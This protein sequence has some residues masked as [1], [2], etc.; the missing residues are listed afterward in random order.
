ME[1]RYLVVPGLRS[2]RI[3]IV[4]TK[5]DPRNPKIVKVIE[6]E[7]LAKRTGYSRPHTIHCGPDGIYVS[8]LGSPEGEG[9]GGIFVMDP[10]TFEV[11]GKWELDRGPQ[12]FSYD[13]WWHLG[14]DTMITSE[15]G[16]PKMF[17]NG[18]IPEAILGGEYG[19]ALH[20]WDLHKRRHKQVL[21]LGP[22]YQLP[23]ELRPA[24]DPTQAYGFV[25]VV[26]SNEDLSAS[27]W[28]WYREGN[29]GNTNWKI[30]SSM[31]PAG[32]PGNCDSMT[33]PTPSTPS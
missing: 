9:P 3:H 15:W 29:N 7:T 14:H 23:F 30:T 32:A 21:E 5:P 19:H 10:E 1:R 2:S 12:Y 25:G 20:V 26:I 11:K 22:Q 4:D 28:L 31:C 16:T 33:S 18:L 27:V 8:A 17:E 13:F 24:H 6:P